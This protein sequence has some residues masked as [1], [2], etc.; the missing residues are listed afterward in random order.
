LCDS[1]LGKLSDSALKCRVIN[2]FKSTLPDISKKDNCALSKALDSVKK[3]RDKR[4]AHNEKVEVISLPKVTWVELNNLLS[5]AKNFIGAIG[6]GY[7][8]S[9]YEANGEYILSRDAKRTSN[10]MRR[11]LKN[12]DIYMNN[13]RSSRD[14]LNPQ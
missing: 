9:A 14:T 11:L 10:A 2:H 12:A 1:T 13:E 6:W 7:L 4:I 5:Y 8:G 3:I